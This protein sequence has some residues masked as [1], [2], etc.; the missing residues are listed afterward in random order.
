MATTITLPFRRFVARVDTGSPEAKASY[1]A[2]AQRNALALEECP[3]GE[4]TGKTVKASLVEH[5]F[6]ATFTD[7]KYDA[8]LMTGSY[9]SSANT[10]IA[11]AGMV[12]YRFALPQAY[13]AGSATLVSASLMLARDRFLLPGL[14]QRDPVYVVGRGA[15][16]RR[17]VRQARRAA[18]QPRRA[19]HSGGTG[20]GRGRGRADGS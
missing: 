17:G 10:E 14:E 13:L 5:D 9:D 19:H 15:R 6:T 16:R 3:W 11:Y 18:R 8:F 7:E 20:D 2:L 1:K 12:A 4:A